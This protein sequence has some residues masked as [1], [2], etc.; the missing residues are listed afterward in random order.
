MMNLRHLLKKSKSIAKFLPY[1]LIGFSNGLTMLSLY[2]IDIWLAENGV[3][4]TMIGVMA[5]AKIPYTFKMFF[6][7]ITENYNI[8]YK[9][10][11][12]IP[13][14]K[15]WVLFSEVV[16]LTTFGLISQIHNPNENLL[17][18]FLL[19]FALKFGTSVLHII[20][21]SFE[22]DGVKSENFANVAAAK[23]FGYRLGLLI[24]GAGVISISSFF[25][26]KI[27][28]L[29]IGILS[30][31]SGGIFLRLKEPKIKTLTKYSV[32]NKFIAQRF[33][34]TC[35][36][37]FAKFLLFPIRITSKDQNFFSNLLIIFFIQAGSQMIS[38]MA[39]ILYLEVGFSIFDIATI[40]NCFGTIVTIFGGIFA[41][42]LIKKIGNKNT[43]LVAIAANCAVP[44]LLYLLLNF[45]QMSGSLFVLI[46]L[47]KN[48][49]TGI[50]MSSF[51]AFL[52][53]TSNASIFPTCIYTF[54]WGIYSVSSLIFSSISGIF[55]DYFGWNLFFLASTLLEI[56]AIFI[57]SKKQINF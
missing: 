27:A 48:F 55:V 56:F 5:F 2:S 54:F 57:I 17:I 29:S 50:I 22:T 19:I 31:L 41:P 49:S 51:L 12:N 13:Q 4:K 36:Q 37:I 20:S 3:S 11:P 9:I 30:F 38:K 15:S 14:K 25:S 21:Y 6:I 52:Y 24:S 47:I 10:F 8:L 46:I 44:G 40:V 26:W 34:S 35:A 45:F 1:I 7:P 39:K 43:I 18:I 33:K 42:K 28:F 16:I 32:L 53:K 23:L